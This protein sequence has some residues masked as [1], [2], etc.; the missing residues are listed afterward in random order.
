MSQDA[1]CL[2]A[3]DHLTSR[4]AVCAN[5]RSRLFSTG[6]SAREWDDV[7]NR[8]VQIL[9]APDPWLFAQLHHVR[10]PSPVTDAHATLNHWLKACDVQEAIDA[11]GTPF[12]VGARWSPNGSSVVLAITSSI[13]GG[14]S[15][16]LERL[17]LQG[18]FLALSFEVVLR[19]G[20]SLDEVGRER[21]SVDLITRTESQVLVT[22][23]LG[24]K[25]DCLMVDIILITGLSYSIRLQAGKAQG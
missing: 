5:L 16:A 4:A 15:Q 1:D 7:L 24:V 20:A 9:A 19:D 10:L 17:G 18:A 6:T 8:Y 21:R 13:S 11:W 23:R 12:Q 2:E 14:R 3:S 25:P 22:T